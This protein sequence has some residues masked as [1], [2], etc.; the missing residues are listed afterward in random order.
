MK[1][2]LGPSGVRRLPLGVR[3]QNVVAIKLD[4]I[5]FLTEAITFLPEEDS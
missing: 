5:F 2:F 1:E 3:G 4:V